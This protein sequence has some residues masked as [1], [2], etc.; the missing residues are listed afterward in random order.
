MRDPNDLS[1]LAQVVEH[2]GF[3]AAARATGVPKS[4]L[5]RRVAALE[6]RL[7]V[8]LIQRTSRRCAV[9]ELGR[10]YAARC[11][12]M[13][14]EGSVARALTLLGYSRQD[15]TWPVIGYAGPF[16]RMPGDAA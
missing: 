7:G 3:A 1:Y 15:E 9:T 10:E 11:T 16:V 2:G 13:L 8:R 4:R 14:A 12:A 6:E 5:S